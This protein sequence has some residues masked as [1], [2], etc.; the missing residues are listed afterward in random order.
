MIH[1]GAGRQGARRIV[2]GG[3][4][5]GFE[6]LVDQLARLVR[7]TLRGVWDAGLAR[8]FGVALRV[9]AADL[10]TASWV[11]LCDSRAFQVQSPEVTQIRQKVMAQIRSQGCEKVALLAAS[12]V[13]TMQFKRIA[14]ESHMGTASFPDEKSAL[15]WLQAAPIPLK[16]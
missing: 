12:A 16:T 3:A 1:P 5:G 8:E 14:V 9:A 15:D 13:Y 11:V 7:V 2:R 4:E 10:G 6:I